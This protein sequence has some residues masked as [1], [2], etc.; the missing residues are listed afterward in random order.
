M[1]MAR[2]VVDTE[3]ILG[4][5]AVLWPGANVSHHSQIG[6]NTFLSPG[7]I[8]CGKAFVGSSCFIGAGA[9]IT[10]G[11]CLVDESFVKASTRYSGGPLPRWQS[12][13]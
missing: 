5:L 2:A 6:C 10:D 9:V 7:A 4:D 1:V 11:V 13:A 12:A 3:A 8:V